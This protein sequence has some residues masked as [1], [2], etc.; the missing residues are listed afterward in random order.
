MG[1]VHL[2]RLSARAAWPAGAVL[3]ALAPAPAAAQQAWAFAQSEIVDPSTISNTADLDF[4][5]IAPNAGGGNVL[6]SPSAT[7]VCTTTGGLVRTGPCKAA[8]FT[9]LTFIGGGLRVM[10][11]SGNS[12]TLTGP[13]GATMQV[14]AFTFGG[15][16]TTAYTG[17]NGANHHFDVTSV[18]GSYTF[19]VGGRLVVGPGQLPG[20]YTG[21]FDVRITYN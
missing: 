19:Y 15:F 16:G 11:P 6:L 4:G 2:G 17:N 12:I 3:A 14:N 7:A 20:V 13:S 21:T 10:R 5:V 8:V 9:G 18:D 1:S